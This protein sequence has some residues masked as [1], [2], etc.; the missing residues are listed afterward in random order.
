MNKQIIGAMGLLLVGSVFSI[1]VFTL[2]LA[3][4]MPPNLLYAVIVGFLNGFFFAYLCF[5]DQLDYIRRDKGY[6]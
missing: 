3:L 4:G 5:K 2:F 6:E 1:L